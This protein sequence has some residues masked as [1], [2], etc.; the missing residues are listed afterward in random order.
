MFDFI[1]LSLTKP[2]A[3][4]Y[5]RT[6]AFRKNISHQHAWCGRDEHMTCELLLEGERNRLKAEDQPA[7]RS[8]SLMTDATEE[9][10][11]IDARRKLL[12]LKKDNT[13]FTHTHREHAFS[14]VLL[15]FVCGGS[16]QA[17]MYCHYCT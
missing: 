11:E 6:T 8:L 13:C 5:S 9:R 17:R 7:D 14:V 15:S 3:R 16:H 2:A 1:R 12:N 4:F 10:E